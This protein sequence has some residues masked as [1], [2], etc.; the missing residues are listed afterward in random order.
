M[1]NGYYSGTYYP[2]Y[3]RADGRE[4]AQTA[5]K[6]TALCSFGGIDSLLDAVDEGGPDSLVA[7]DIL[8]D[9]FE[10]DDY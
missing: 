6:K 10:D 1:T 9:I 5:E 8:D 3:H 4:A 7:Q 2:I